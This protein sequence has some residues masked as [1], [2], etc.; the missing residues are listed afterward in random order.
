MSKPAKPGNEELN[1]FIAIAH[2][3]DAVQVEIFIAA[4]PARVFRPSPTG[5]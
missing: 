2:D 1:G 4:P 3:H 5:A